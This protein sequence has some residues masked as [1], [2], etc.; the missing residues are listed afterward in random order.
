MWRR[1]LYAG[2]SADVVCTYVVWLCSL[3]TSSQRVDDLLIK[4]THLFRW[5]IWRGSR[6]CFS[7]EINPLSPGPRYNKQLTHGATAAL[8]TLCHIIRKNTFSGNSSL[9]LDSSL[10]RWQ[11]SVSAG[12]SG[13]LQGLN[14]D[15]SNDGCHAKWISLL[16]WDFK[17]LCFLEA[18]GA[19]ERMLT[20]HYLNA[21][22]RCGWELC[23]MDVQDFINQ[24]LF[25]FFCKATDFLTRFQLIFQTD[26]TPKQTGMRPW[27]QI[28]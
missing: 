16:V 27:W 26:V 5:G 24:A 21:W 11:C 4:K 23:E 8:K 25:F 3:G 7:Y 9:S 10:D 19:T 12:P 17:G 20:G 18:D 28:K 15:R 13:R 6:A 22:K 14:W 2:V 1:A